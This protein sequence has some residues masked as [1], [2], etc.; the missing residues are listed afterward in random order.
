[1]GSGVELGTRGDVP[2]APRWTGVAAK[3]GG[4][5]RSPRRRR[6]RPFARGGS[7]EE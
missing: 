5:G 4:G 7:R 1:M 6:R 3:E 2:A